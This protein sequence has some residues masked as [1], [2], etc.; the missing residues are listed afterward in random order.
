M[1]AFFYPFYSALLPICIISAQYQKTLGFKSKK[2][3]IFG[4]LFQ[5]LYAHT[6]LDH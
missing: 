6:V 5:A 2:K 4:V 1:I 3:I